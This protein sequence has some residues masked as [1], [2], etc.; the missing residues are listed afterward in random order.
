MPAACGCTTSNPGFSDCNCRVSSC[1]ALRFRH[2]FL[3]VLIPVLLGGNRDSV[4]PGDEWFKKTLQRGQRTVNILILA[5]RLVIA[6]TGAMLIVGHEAPFLISAL[7]C[8]IESRDHT[9]KE[10]NSRQVSG[11]SDASK[12]QSVLI[13]TWRVKIILTKENKQKKLWAGHWLHNP[14]IRATIVQ[15]K[16][17]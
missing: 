7:A 1:F 17:E 3:S 13:G 9:L 15:E 5:T 16:K 11:T 10:G 14:I 4:R 2:C 6:S 8:R 12:T